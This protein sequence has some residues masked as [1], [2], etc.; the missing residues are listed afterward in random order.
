L[1]F[2]TVYL[3]YDDLSHFFITPSAHPQLSSKDRS[4]PLQWNN[5]KDRSDPLPLL[6]IQLYICFCSV[7]YAVVE[8]ALVF[9]YCFYKLVVKT[10]SIALQ[11]ALVIFFLYFKLCSLT[12]ILFQIYLKNRMV[13]FYFRNIHKFWSEKWLCDFCEIIRLC[14]LLQFWTDYD[15]ILR[16]YLNY[17]I[18]QIINTSILFHWKWIYVYKYVMVV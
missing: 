12:Q 18:V 14:Q 11:K 15:E 16:N 6:H 1:A 4:D 9:N 2:T 10:G 7:C 5:G 8:C 3:V 13:F 17:Q